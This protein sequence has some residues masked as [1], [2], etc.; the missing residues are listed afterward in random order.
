MKNIVTVH[1][2]NCIVNVNVKILWDGGLHR[3]LD[4]WLALKR[5]MLLQ[6]LVKFVTY[7]DTSG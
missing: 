4:K 2:K 7:L 5:G 1:V 3:R 6:M